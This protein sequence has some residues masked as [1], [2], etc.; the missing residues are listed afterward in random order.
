M[1]TTSAAGPNTLLKAIRRARPTTERPWRL[2]GVDVAP[3]VDGQ[4][5]D[6]GDGVDRPARVGSL[7]D[8]LTGSAVLANELLD[9]LPFRIIERAVGG[10]WFEVHVV[11]G[12]ESLVPTDARVDIGPGTRAPFLEQ[13]NRWCH[14]VLARNPSHL[15][16]FDYGMATTAALAAR[17]GWLRTYRQHQRGDNP[18]HEPGRWDITTDIAADQ[19]PQPVEVAAQAD[20]LAEWGIDTLVEEGRAYWREHVARPDL[21]AFAMRSRVSE[22]EALTDRDGLGSWLVLHYTP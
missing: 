13:A 21:A 15:C 18:L 11:D 7:P 14:S 5:D 17:G 19:L 20:F 12:K 22:A 2:I 9:N 10:Q 1:C 6:A 16:L 3:S 4:T 8:D